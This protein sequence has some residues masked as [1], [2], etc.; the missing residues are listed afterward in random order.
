MTLLDLPAAYAAA[1]AEASAG[2]PVVEDIPP[3]TCRYCGK[4]LRPFA[5]RSLDGHVRCAVTLEF[6]RAVHALWWSSPTVSD[7]Q[8]AAVCGV[9]AATVRGWLANAE[10]KGRAA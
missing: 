9:S 6:Q 5:S 2:K 3:N 10:R 7:V 1:R 4:Y 8:I